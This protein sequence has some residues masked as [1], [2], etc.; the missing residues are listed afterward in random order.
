MYPPSMSCCG[1]FG[2]GEDPLE[3]GPSPRGRACRCRCPWRRRH[4]RACRR[5]AARPAPTVW[6]SMAVPPRFLSCDC[7][8]QCA[9]TACFTRFEERRVPPLARVEE[10]AVAR[11][12]VLQVVVGRRA[13]RGRGRGVDAARLVLRCSTR[14]PPLSLE[15]ALELESLGAQRLLLEQTG[16]GADRAPPKPVV[17]VDAAG[18]ADRSRRV[19][20]GL[21]LLDRHLLGSRASSSASPRSTSATARG[22]GSACRR[23][24]WSSA[25][26]FD[27]CGI[28]SLPGATS[29]TC[30]RGWVGACWSTGAVRPRFCAHCRAVRV[31]HGDRPGFDAL[32]PGG[33]VPDEDE[34]SRREWVEHRGQGDRDDVSLFSAH[35]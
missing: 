19:R 35:D 33:K 14:Q 5:A 26:Y 18:G 32:V 28:L 34:G 9:D 16:S 25:R 1:G 12:H 2:N 24:C 20:P 11:G 29:T 27:S 4:R 30:P 15:S 7:G 22:R 31:A 23:G 6:R 8:S 17:G 10:R 21:A 13:A 3:R